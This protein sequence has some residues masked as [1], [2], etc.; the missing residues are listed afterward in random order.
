MQN[1]VDIKVNF[2]NIREMQWG[3]LLKLYVINFQLKNDNEYLIIPVEFEIGNVQ[4][5]LK[6]NLVS[7]VILKRWLFTEHPLCR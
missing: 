3:E 2:N 4:S 7:S 5:N 1:L 6:H